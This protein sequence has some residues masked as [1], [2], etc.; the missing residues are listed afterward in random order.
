M[1]W[2]DTTQMSYT[3]PAAGNHTAIL[4]Q[5]REVYM[6]VDGKGNVYLTSKG[7]PAKTSAQWIVKPDAF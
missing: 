3:L 5:S 1:L 4:N 7:D 6:W 2:G